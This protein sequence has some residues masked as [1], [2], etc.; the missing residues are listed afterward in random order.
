MLPTSHEEFLE[1]YKKNLVVPDFQI[2]KEVLKKKEFSKNS[3][4]ENSVK[5][6]FSG[7]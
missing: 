1:A 6:H 5:K 2:I 4:C 7:T 3:F